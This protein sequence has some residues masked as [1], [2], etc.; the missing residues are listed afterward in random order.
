MKSLKIL[1]ILLLAIILAGCSNMI[2]PPADN[3]QSISNVTSEE[4]L[5]NT[6]EIVIDEPQFDPENVLIG[7]GYVHPDNA[8]Y[9]YN[10][11]EY[12][13]EERIGTSYTLNVLGVSI[14]LPY[15]CSK[16][17]EFPYDRIFYDDGLNLVTLNSITNELMTFLI[18]MPNECEGY[19][20]KTEE[21]SSEKAIIVAEN[22]VNEFSP[23]IDLNDYT[24]AIEK[25]ENDGDYLIVFYKYINSIRVSTI[26]IVMD[27]CGNI[28]WY[29][30]FDK[31]PK[32]V[33]NFTYEEYLNAAIKLMEEYHTENNMYYNKKVVDIIDYKIPSNSP[34]EIIYM[35]ETDTFSVQYFLEF[36]VVYEDGSISENIL[37]RFYYTFDSE[38]AVIQ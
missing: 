31:T 37:N 6:S 14:E 12:V 2:K 8:D 20:E 34:M 13:D 33:P 21:I 29:R 9:C 32:Y 3:N 7:Y 38:Y 28:F 11:N 19:I 1:A 4:S 30:N 15:D 23:I 24:V 35:P 18:P 16:Q 25:D 10:S 5:S 17:F 26:E 27:K 36:D 22:F